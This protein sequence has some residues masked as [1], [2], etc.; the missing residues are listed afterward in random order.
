MPTDNHHQFLKN[1]SQE[2]GADRCFICGCHIPEG[3]PL[4][5]REHVFPQWLLREL[6]LWDGTI[7]QLNDELLQYRK[8][9]VPCCKPCNGGDL[10]PVEVRVKAAFLDGIAAF[11]ALNRRDLFI[12]LGKI[13]YGLIYKESLRPRYVREQEGE[14]LIPESHLRSVSFH[15]FL[16]QSAGGFVSWEPD[17]PGPASFHFFEC[18]DDER[19]RR[20]FDY[21]DDIY[22]PIIGL[23]MG[24]IGVVCIL[25]DWGRS[26]N[27][28]QLQLNAAREMKLHPT[29]FREVYARLSY[30]TKVSWKDKKHMIIGGDDHALVIA[31]DPGPFSGTFVLD[32]YVQ[33]LSHI[34]EV[35]LEAVYRDGFTFSTICD[36]F[37]THN[38]AASHDVVF[39]APYGTTGLWPAHRLSTAHLAPVQPVTD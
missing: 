29:Q 31:G 28:Q 39:T 36:E 20:R 16:L 17:A 30:M 9:T 10:S 8:L 32:E 4:R 34:W 11:R 13:Y 38:V 37:G 1:R 6:D 24:R 3:S 5:S 27:V 25:Q 21:M 35:P 12:W 7:H 23:R 2:F 22:A 14:R 33:T 26:E 15:H 19:S 18:L